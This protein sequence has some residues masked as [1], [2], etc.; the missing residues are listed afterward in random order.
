MDG[1]MNQKARKEGTEFSVF[2][3]PY[4]CVHCETLCVPR[5]YP[6]RQRITAKR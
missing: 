5:G 6:K 1:G 3:Y 4:L 2:K